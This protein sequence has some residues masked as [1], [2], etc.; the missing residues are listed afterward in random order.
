MPKI[1]RFGQRSKIRTDVQATPSQSIQQAGMVSRSKQNLANQVGEFATQ[2][3]KQRALAE[4]TSAD[5]DFKTKYSD[6]SRRISDQKEVEFASENKGYKGY[7]DSILAEEDAAAKELIESS[8]F[9]DKNRL[10]K[11]YD[12]KRIDRSFKLKQLEN[13]KHLDWSYSN[14]KNN[15]E[16]MAEGAETVEDALNYERERD[17]F[18]KKQALTY[19]PDRQEVFKKMR[20]LGAET[21]I[22]K[23]A[24]GDFTN[25]VRAKKIMESD[26]L[27]SKELVG[28]ISTKK[29][30]SLK[31]YIDAKWMKA[32]K[33]A[34]TQKLISGQNML[35]Q[36]Q[37]DLIQNNF[38]PVK[39]LAFEERADILEKTAKNNADIPGLA[40]Q[41]KNLKN[42]M[43]AFNESSKTAEEMKVMPLGSIASMDFK[44]GLDPKDPEGSMLQL[45][46]NEQVRK[47]YLEKYTKDPVGAA[48]T[49]RTDL[50][51]GS[52][53]MRDYLVSVKGIS[54]PPYMSNAQT[55]HVVDAL[56]NS[57]NKGQ[58]LTD[59]YTSF[60]DGNGPKALAQASVKNKNLRPFV[61]LSEFDNQLTRD[62]LLSLD[63]GAVKK[64]FTDSGNKLP[65]LRNAINATKFKEF[66]VAMADSPGFLDGVQNNLEKDIMDQVNRN[67]DINDAAEISYKRIIE[68]NYNIIEEGSTK[69]ALPVN[70][71]VNHED[72]R[73]FV[74]RFFNPKNI[75]GILEAYPNF[76][77]EDQPGVDPEQFNNDPKEFF[78][79]IFDTG[80]YQAKINSTR[81][82]LKPA[83]IG[84]SGLPKAIKVRDANNNLVDLEVKWSEINAP[85]IGMRGLKELDT[86]KGRFHQDV[87]DELNQQS[88]FLGGLEEVNPDAKRRLINNIEK[89]RAANR[90][91]QNRAVE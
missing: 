91:I 89:A 29:R 20:G 83:Y 86:T 41:I 55:A 33:M 25:L 13:S 70:S 27:E 71:N 62:R 11:T 40:L 56:E 1:P 12:T 44:T 4:R 82:G 26:D 39:K 3:G 31:K 73:G 54:N 64:R 45:Q 63:Y 43:N 35:Q 57:P 18:T 77:L 60:P 75:S 21:F 2:I 88:S 72:A 8:G 28:N 36:A 42:K 66:S 23:L 38:T 7:A 87:L 74:L 15:F 79:A 47:N 16:K 34:L 85:D 10:Q 50:I 19:R 76:K 51:P 84:D 65:D 17:L 68:N 61:V 69:I 5:L 24:D 59:F 78:K 53:E 32:R 14:D 81:D 48:I 49:E 6:V 90:R 80:D 9:F 58:E 22:S 46:S 67:V 37:F 52:D 30:R